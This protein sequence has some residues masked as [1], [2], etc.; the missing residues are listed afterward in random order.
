MK[1]NASDSAAFL[2]V[3]QDEVVELLKDNEPF[4]LVANYAGNRG[5]F[6]KDNIRIGEKRQS[7]FPVD[8]RKSVVEQAKRK[9]TIYEPDMSVAE[10]KRRLEKD[11]KRIGIV[12]QPYKNDDFKVEYGDYV[13]V[14]DIH[15]DGARVINSKGQIDSLPPSFVNIV[16]EGKPQ[17]TQRAGKGKREVQLSVDKKDE[18]INFRAKLFAEKKRVGIVIEACPEMKLAVRDTIEIID[19][20]GKN[21][22]ILTVENRLGYV[23]RSNIQEIKNPNFEDE[24]PQRAQ[25]S[26]INQVKA[27]N[28]RLC[29]ALQ[30]YEDVHNST[31]FKVKKGE[32]LQ[33]RGKF[34]DNEFWHLVEN[35]S[36]KIFPIP[37]NIVNEVGYR[38][39]QPAIEDAL[40]KVLTRLNLNKLLP[41][42]TQ[43]PVYNENQYRRINDLPGRHPATRDYQAVPPRCNAREQAAFLKLIKETN[44]NY[45][46]V[47][48]TFEARHSSEVTVYAGEVVQMMNPTSSLVRTADGSAGYVPQVYLAKQEQQPPQTPFST[49][50]GTMGRQGPRKS[51]FEDGTIFND[52]PTAKTNPRMPK[53]NTEQFI[54]NALSRNRE[55]FRAKYAFAAEA[56]GVSLR[57]C[58][59]NRHLMFL[60]VI[61]P[62][63]LSVEENEV[64]EMYEPVGDGGRYRVGNV[65][66]REGIVPGYVLGERISAQHNEITDQ[67][68]REAEFRKQRQGQSSK[69]KLKTD[70]GRHR[71]NPADY[72]SA[73]YVKIL[74]YLF[75][76]FLILL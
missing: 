73:P 36:G 3:R 66:G 51:L 62:K 40:T 63:D 30:D 26:F 59:Y 14:V 7:E 22:R 21:Y 19:V 71:S 61:F 76:F 20:E 15:D 35:S 70:E 4:I 52:L 54:R 12:I 16:A 25:D 72:T 42:N 2:N 60:Y 41:D 8:G 43:A 6:K 68:K 58:C 49:L 27:K 23:P 28:G 24:A 1:K 47:K 55:V 50:R 10:Y 38:N 57:N 5:L 13:E 75:C 56:E 53:P 11:C 69:S 74:L 32:F 44:G 45:C 18:A 34:D 37:A 65:Y 46:I 17:I 29:M 64:L 31:P 33:I 9:S 39:E 48:E 67:I